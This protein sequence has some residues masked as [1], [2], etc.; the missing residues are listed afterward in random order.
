[1]RSI[2]SLALL[3]TLVACNDTAPPAEKAPEKAPEKAAEKKAPVCSWTANSSAATVGWTAFKFTEKTG[4]GGGFDKVTA[5]GG[6]AADAPWKA[7]DGLTFEIDTTSVNSKNPDRDA[8][9]QA[10]FFGAMTETTA[11]TGKVKAN[12]AGKATLTITMNGATHDVMVDVKHTE[13]NP[14][15]LSGT[16]DVETWGAG[17]AIASLNKVCDGLHTGKDGVSKLWSEVAI[18][19]ELP[20]KKTCR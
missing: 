14:L 13:G 3:S 17:A 20:L 16:L 4:V 6:E 19:A 9:I 11:I 1:M 10:S 15:S 5:A 18:T 8:K 12:S 7:I 2:V